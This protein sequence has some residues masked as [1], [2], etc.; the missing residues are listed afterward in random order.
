MA[1]SES[2]KGQR[3]LVVGA[4]RS[5]LAAAKRKM[6]DAVEPLCALLYSY[7]ALEVL[8]TLG[9]IGD[10]RALDAVRAYRASLGGGAY[11][12]LPFR[13]AADNALSALGE[14]QPVNGPERAG[15]H[16]QRNDDTERHPQPPVGK[17]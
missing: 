11:E 6:A 1:L 4:G 17:Q 5:G 9:E 16:E 12:T 15:K 3:I 8:D 2:V 10:A 14:P 13:L 7:D